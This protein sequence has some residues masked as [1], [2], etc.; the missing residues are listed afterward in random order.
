M[1]EEESLPWRSETSKIQTPEDRIRYMKIVFSPHAYKKIM[2]KD[3]PLDLKKSF[4]TFLLC[5]KHNH[6]TI[7]IPKA[8]WLSVITP[9]CEQYICAYQMY[10]KLIRII[11][12]F[13]KSRKIMD[14][15]DEVID[16]M[17][18]D[19]MEWFQGFLR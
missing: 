5:M 10:P 4:F 3:F 12:R 19:F 11:E 6:K 2:P 7:T 16:F 13:Q 9:Y 15:R 18:D 8:V 14:E 1:Y 17:C